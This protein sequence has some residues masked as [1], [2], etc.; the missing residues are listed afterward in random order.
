MT[1]KTCITFIPILLAT[2]AWAASK[3]Q[4]SSRYSDLEKD[5]KLESTAPDPTAG[6]TPLHCSDVG[7]YEV[8]IYF[9]A[10]RECLSLIRKG[11]PLD[12]YETVMP[13]I[14]DK[15]VR[16]KLEWRM[17]NGKPFA[18]IFRQRQ[19]RTNTNGNEDQVGEKLLVKGLAG[20]QQLDEAVDTMKDPQANETARRKADDFYLRSSNR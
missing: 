3:L 12:K 14:C 19:W 13:G 16:R 6:D 4:F 5:C 1:Y 10:T 11:P 18:I 8:S 15:A 17:V 9:S 2:G 20:F 7:N